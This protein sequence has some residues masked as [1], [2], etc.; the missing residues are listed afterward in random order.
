MGHPIGWNNPPGPG[1][2]PP[3]AG[4]VPWTAQGLDD[5]GPIPRQ[6]PAPGAGPEGVPERQ[7]VGVAKVLGLIVAALGAVNFIWGFLPELTAS[8]SQESLSVFAVGPAYVPVLLLIG[9]LLA[10]AALLPGTEV[11]RLSVAAVSVG[12]AAGAIV[13]LGTEGPVQLVSTTQV[14]KG[15][16]AILLVIFG[17]VQA[18]VAIGAYV[19]GADGVQWGR[20]SAA[21]TA[22]VPGAA[23][24]VGSAAVGPAPF[25]AA[26][27]GWDS[28]PSSAPHPAAGA[29]AGTPAG[30]VRPG[31]YAPWQGQDPRGIPADERPTGPQQIVVG[32]ESRAE[33]P[34]VTR[35]DLTPPAAVPGSPDAADHATPAA[36][37][38]HEHPSPVGDAPGQNS[39][40]GADPVEDGSVQ[41]GQVQDGP[42]QDGPAKDTGHSS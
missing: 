34:P 9:G 10:L 12:G 29:G 42:V 35:A 19:V 30:A 20:R 3:P 5:T 31:W 24:A 39:P 40:V 2:P 21:G 25:Q 33:P 27:A 18:V 23:A 36:E 13:S 28:H 7:G 14:S 8:R 26:A 17:I 38:P 22:A 4:A 1:Y 15:M 11:S 32:T 41:D 6:A 16:G 37:S